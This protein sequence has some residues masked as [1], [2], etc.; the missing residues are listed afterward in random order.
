MA[1]SDDIDRVV[2]AE[3]Q[4]R[5]RSAGAVVIEGPKAC[6]KTATGRRCA[7]S[8]VSFDTDADAR[9]LVELDPEL[10]LFGETPRLLDAWQVDV[11]RCPS[12]PVSRRTAASCSLAMP[13]LAGT[14]CTS[15][16]AS[17][18]ASSV[19]SIRFVCAVHAPGEDVWCASGGDQGPTV[20][21]SRTP[22]Q[23]FRELR[24]ALFRKAARGTSVPAQPPRR[25]RLM[26]EGG[27]VGSM[28]LSCGP[29]AL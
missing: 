4:R 2:D 3:L 24:W 1:T 11:R 16:C 20:R 10:L 6:G 18:P 28:P 15:S 25:M 19:S 7:R 12:R 23:T 9:R 26:P 5:L 22:N 8:V 21:T 14:A 29:L 17:H 13:G 27:P